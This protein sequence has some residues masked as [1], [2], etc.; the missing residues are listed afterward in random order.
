MDRYWMRRAL[1]LARKGLGTTSPNPLV[2]AIVVDNNRKQVGQ[3][4]HRRAGE[5]HAEVWPS[6][7]RAPS[8]KAARSTSHSNPALTKAEPLPAWIASSKAGSPVW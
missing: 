7:R 1:A 2:G 3:G 5:K 8:R 6:K 4:Y